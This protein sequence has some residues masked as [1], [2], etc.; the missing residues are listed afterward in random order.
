MRFKSFF[1]AGFEGSTG[2]NRHG[3]WIDQVCATQH[4]LFVE[5]DYLRL[6]EVGIQTVREVVRWPLVD[7]GGRYD[8]STVEPLL[9]AAARHGMEIIYD[10]F[11]FGYPDDIDLFSDDFPPRFADYCYAVAS[12]ITRQTSEIFSFTPVNEPS[13]FAWAAGEAGLF[14][15]HQIGR[16]W[17]LKVQLIKA[18]IQGINAIHTASPAARIVNADPLCRVALPADNTGWHDE[19]DHFNNHIVF[20]S[21]DMLCG[22]LLPELGGSPKHL[23]IVGINYY[24]TNQWEWRQTSPLAQGDPRCCSLSDLIRTVWERYG[25]EILISETSAVGQRRAPWLRELAHEV[26]QVLND[27]IPLRGV[28]LY[29]ILGMPEWHA[30]DEWTRMGLWDLVEQDGKL[31]RVPVTEMLQVLRD[32]PRHRHHQALAKHG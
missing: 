22:R 24:W 14:A 4:D 10:L 25:T 8:F 30:P 29:P 17:E 11:H 18:A 2:Y 6:R 12:F 15:P 28:C 27:Q 32:L 3:Q 19:V 16:S 21:W 20:Q 5:Q 7:R 26:E 1:Q 31:Q 13:F 9:A 23:D